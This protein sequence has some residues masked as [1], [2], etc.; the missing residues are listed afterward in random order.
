M[1]TKSIVL[2]VFAIIIVFVGIWMY[3][4]VPATSMGA[5]TTFEECA[6]L[7][8]VMESYPEQCNTPDGKHFVH[9]IT[10]PTND[11]SDVIQ[12]TSP[13]VNATVASPMTITG[14]ARGS[15]YF[16]ASF[17][18]QLIDANGQI[19]AQAPAQAQGE[20]MTTDFVP[21]KL[22]LPFKK[23]YTVTGT[24][25]LH[26]DNPSGDPVRDKEVRIP[27]RFVSK[28]APKTAKFDA[29]IT[30]GMGEDVMLPDGLLIAIKEIND[31]RCKPGVQCIW[32]G[33][34][35][36]LITRANN[37][38]EGSVLEEFRLGTVNNKSLTRGV[39]T[40]TLQSATPTSVTL[41]VTSIAPTGAANKA[42]IAGYV[43]VGPTCPVE[44]NPPDPAC[45]DKALTGAQVLVKNG[46]KIV[47]QTTTDASGNFKVSVPVDSYIISV[48]PAGGAVLPRCADSVIQATGIA[49]ADI[50][51]DSGI[52]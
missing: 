8:P 2:S 42:F 44:K 28:P 15:W 21:F 10:V 11:L 45:A 34:I 43:H 52:R 41:V 50:A 35:S 20:W 31:S 18:V 40:F 27:V 46:D 36:V 26:N 23:P 17:P 32:A 14:K 24:L 12:V 33:E 25:I 3:L 22:T 30:L 38:E 19:L 7:Y 4:K 37:G 13:V 48:K 49:N 51:C 6:A 16:E 47:A 5:I 1:K 39:H 9:E 29:P